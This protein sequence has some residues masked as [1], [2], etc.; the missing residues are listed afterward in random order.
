MCALRLVTADRA[1]PGAV[2]I[3]VPPARRTFLIVRPRPLPFDLLLLAEA[4]GTAFRDFDR[5]QAGRVAEA[6]FDALS[7]WSRG[8]AGRVEVSAARSGGVRAEGFH[9]CVH[10][11][12]FHLLACGR[13]PGQAYDA[14]SFPDAAT[15]RTAAEQLGA[16]LSPPEGA[17]QEVYLNTRHFQR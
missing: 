3:L 8:G 10:V 15:A 7:E 4:R 16:L 6:L 11:G 13:R 17:E 1:G 9:V 2:G 14:L 5:E 12:P